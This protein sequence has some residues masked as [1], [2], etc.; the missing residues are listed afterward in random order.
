MQKD[1]VL[2]DKVKRMIEVELGW[3]DSARWINQDFIALSKRMYD[4]TG[5][6]LS[7]ITLKRLW[8][9]VNYDGLPQAYT[10]NTLA[11]FV[12]YDSWRDFTV[13]NDD[14]AVSE[15][16]QLKKAPSVLRRHWLSRQAIILLLV[17]VSG[18]IY[19]AFK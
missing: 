19:G 3:G 18:L 14:P 9:K 17:V 11:N 13:K 8:G 7:P 16:P 12:G 10:L 4:K 1:A 2:L 6:S 15:V 5:H